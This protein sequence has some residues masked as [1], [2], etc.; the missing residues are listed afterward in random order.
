[1]FCSAHLYLLQHPKCA[2]IE[3]I[4]QLEEISTWTKICASKIGVV[5]FTKTEK[6]YFK[7]SFFW[8]FFYTKCKPNYY[9]KVIFSPKLL[10]YPLNLKVRTYRFVSRD[11][12]FNRKWRRSSYQKRWRNW[13]NVFEQF[14]CRIVNA[15]Q[16]EV[17]LKIAEIQLNIVQNENIGLHKKCSIKKWTHL[18]KVMQT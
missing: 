16:S 18:K 12:A 11:F 7:F 8:K 13:W 1:M 2:K 4:I 9:C 17:K 6:F 10:I 3:Q 5:T 14:E 15:Q